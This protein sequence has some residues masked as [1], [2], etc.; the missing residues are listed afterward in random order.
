MK[1]TVKSQNKY[2]HKPLRGIPMTSLICLH[3][4]LK[5]II[6]LI[7]KKK[8]DIIRMGDMPTTLRQT[9]TQ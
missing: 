7:K 2:M 4:I 1:Y 8:V 6:L 9:P 3:L 5:K